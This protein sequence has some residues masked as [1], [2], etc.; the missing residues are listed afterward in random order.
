MALRTTRQIT[1]V[2]G[3]SNAGELRVT[4]QNAAVLATDTGS[5]RVY[6]QMIEVLCWD[7][8]GTQ[9]DMAAD[10]ALSLTSASIGGK[11]YDLAATVAIAALDEAYLNLEGYGTLVLDCTSDWDA[12]WARSAESTNAVTDE[13]TFTITRTR[14][15]TG[16][17]ALTQVL[18]FTGPRYAGATDTIALTQVGYLCQTFEVSA[19][20]IIYPTVASVSSG[21]QRLSAT[22]ALTLLSLA[23]NKIFVRSL[24]NALELSDSA[25]IA[26][27]Y[28]AENTLSLTSTAVYGQIFANANSTISITQSARLNPLTIG[29]GSGY[30]FDLQGNTIVLQSV[31]TTN[32]HMLAATTALS[33]TDV[34]SATQP[35]YVVAESEIQTITN[36][37][38]PETY[39]FVEVV[40]GLQDAAA[41]AFIGAPFVLHQYLQ[42]TQVA[43][44]TRI[45]VGATAVSASDA[46]S[47]T[48]AAY[49]NVTGAST[50]YLAF[51]Q[52]TLVDICDPASDLLELVDVAS[53]ISIRSLSATS[54]LTISHG[55][56]F[57]VVG[58]SLCDYAPFV[59][60]GAV[61]APTPPSGSLAAPLTG[62]TV[63]FQ[64]VYP[65]TGAVTDS[66]TLRAPNL[67]NKDRLSFNRIVRETRGGTLIVYADPI[68]PKVQTLVLTFSGLTGVEAR[69]LVDFFDD[70][71]GLEVGLL[72]W[73]QRY[74][75]GFIT[76]P[77]DPII[78]DALDQFTASFTFE[79]E[80]DPTWSP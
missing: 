69:A 31:A 58:P 62:I 76:T 20:N 36:V 15:G 53:V 6:R 10:N 57:W 67:G 61:G 75:R 27:Y 1:E 41:A 4:R 79:G 25:E 34:L 50:S 40:S 54:T 43:S 24:S 32:I 13:S 48:D 49:K 68:W 44:V 19:N 39:T 35:R 23:D 12:V 7:S 55:L 77:S 9:Y 18:E 22:S 72:D 78:E 74:W 45:K 47:L 64:L 66:V 16:A 2:L 65:A 59:G 56:G 17:L 37:F 3:T 42:P 29:P 71:L 14:G 73:E 26:V 21:S 70:Y 63:P 52:Q 38:D 11:I 8:E 60:E 80:L 28:T 51:T 5:A 33:V 46:L 30:D